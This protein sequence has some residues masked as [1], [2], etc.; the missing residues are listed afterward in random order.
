MQLA[1][2]FMTHVS[3]KR[4]VTV[5][6]KVYWVHTQHW[7]QSWIARYHAAAPGLAREIA[8]RKVD[9]SDLQN[10][11]IDGSAKGGND[12]NRFT[13]EDFA[14]EILIEFASRNKLPLKIITEAAVFKNVDPDFKSGYKTAP[15]T[16]AGF[17]V[18]LAAVTGA[19]DIAKNCHPVAD[20]DLKPGDIFLKWNKSHV[21]VLT[22]VSSN[23]IEIMQG[24]FPGLESNIRR[25]VGWVIS[26][27]YHRLS[28]YDR[29][30]PVYLGIP[31]QSAV[32]E[33]RGGQWLYQRQYGNYHE[34]DNDVWPT[35]PGHLRWNFLDFN[36][37]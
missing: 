3:D 11:P 21:Q 29:E 32:Y 19:H 8:A 7:D 15:P 1:S 23:R 27:L 10:E 5:Q 13:C 34:W 37:L 35:M 17:A 4:P 22:S 30:S 24:N 20:S 33:N 14:F 9:M 25:G 18:D 31:V 12:V 36:H 26:K 28:A 2:A 16:P 6:C